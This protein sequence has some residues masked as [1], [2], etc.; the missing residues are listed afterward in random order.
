MAPR[1]ARAA[2]RCT[3]VADA[4]LSPGGRAEPVLV[5]WQYVLAGRAAGQV[6]QRSS[7]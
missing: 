6:A 4:I 7:R 1:K 2:G 5:P 3:A